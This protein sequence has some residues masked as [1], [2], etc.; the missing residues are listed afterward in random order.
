MYKIRLPNFEGPFDLLL[1]FI[2][3]DELNIYDIPIARV[4]SEF[5]EYIRIIRYFDLELAGEFILMASTLM[6]IKAQLLL[7]KPKSDSDSEVEDPRTALVQK[8]LEYKQMKDA[9]H[10]LSLKADDNKYI[11]Y[12]NLFDADKEVVEATAEYK[13][14]T[15]FEL[16]KAFQKV[17]EKAKE[18]SFDHIVEMQNISAEEKAKDIISQLKTKSRLSFF[19]LTQNQSVSHLIATFLAI[20]DLMKSQIIMIYQDEHFDDIIITDRTILN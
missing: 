16:I 9:A 20:L 1:Y 13:N 17:M 3:R 15:L 8:L 10:E 7:P 11:L 19:T 18:E 12:R 14:A 2:K 4:T 5:L 6:Y